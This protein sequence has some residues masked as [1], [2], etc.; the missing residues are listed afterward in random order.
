MV[1]NNDTIK[2]RVEQLERCMKE[3]DNK[4]D[5][6]LTNHLPHLDSRISRLTWLAGLNLFAILAGIVIALLLR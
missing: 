1:K 6:I 4:V 5:Q 2:W 3:V